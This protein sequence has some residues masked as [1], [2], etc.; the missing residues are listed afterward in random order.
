MQVSLLQFAA[1]S[2][3]LEQSA[4]WAQADICSEQ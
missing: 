3:R 1:Q 2:R 4:I